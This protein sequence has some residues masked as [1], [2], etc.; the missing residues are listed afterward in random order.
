MR[1][2]LLRQALESGKTVSKKSKTKQY[3]APSSGVPSRNGSRANS[4]NGS[5]INS[6]AASRVGSRVGSRQGSEEEDSDEESD[7]TGVR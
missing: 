2:Q 6:R 7:A 4:P 3:L 5:A 1:E